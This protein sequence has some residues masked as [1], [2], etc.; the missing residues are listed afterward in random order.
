MFS[1]IKLN[2]LDYLK[3]VFEKTNKT[4]G[5]IRKLSWGLASYFLLIIHK[6]FAD[7]ILI[8]VTYDKNY[9]AVFHQT[10]EVMQCYAAL[11]ITDAIN[12][13]S[14]DSSKLSHYNFLV[15]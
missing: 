4:L 3:T 11:A 2:F 9:N 6:S 5:F 1:E 10:M 7:I 15:F 13:S 12:D 14:R 8:M